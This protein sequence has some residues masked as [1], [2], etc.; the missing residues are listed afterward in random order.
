[1]TDRFEVG[2]P[3]RG[4]PARLQP[5]IDRTLRIA[6]GGQMLRQDLGLP[7]HAIGEILLQYR[8]DAAFASWS[9][10]ARSAG[11]TEGPN[12]AA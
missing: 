9:Q 8:R 11:P 3:P 7:L 2:Q 4:V 1:M 5:L 12:C 6:G 10:R